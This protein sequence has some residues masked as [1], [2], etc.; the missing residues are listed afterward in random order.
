MKVGI[1]ACALAAA[2]LFAAPASS[3]VSPPSQ[4][5]PAALGR[6]PSGEI[7]SGQVAPAKA[8]RLLR[9]APRDSRPFGRSY[10]EWVARWTEWAVETEGSVHPLLDRGDCSVNQKGRVW[11][12][13]GS[14]SQ[15]GT[16]IARDCVVPEGTA[17][18][19]ALT[20]GFWLSTPEVACIAADPW[21]KARPKD[22]EYAL[23]KEQV[24]DPIEYPDP[25]RTLS[26]KLDGKS[27]AG[28]GGFFFRSAVFTARL[29][30]DNIFDALGF[31]S[32][33][34]IPAILTRPDVA[35]GFHVFLRP[36]P[37]GRYTLRFKAD[38]DHIDFNP[39][40]VRIRQDVTY[41]LT[42]KADGPA[43]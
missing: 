22:P 34:D 8:A 13:G 32:P 24:L 18:F 35:W 27:A 2:C 1:A 20:S 29:P 36:L 16:P 42:V 28:L 15:D 14:F 33:E 39:E 38:V 17:L 30:D 10:R 41:R 19:V 9:I 25:V 40:P 6:I 43:G 7:E 23:F 31:C 3:G 4:A 5:A 12:L 21:Y 11:F 37:P 26:L